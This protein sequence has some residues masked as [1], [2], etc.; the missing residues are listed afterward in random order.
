MK[1]AAS[2]SASTAGGSRYGCGPLNHSLKQEG[3]N[4]KAPVPAARGL[5]KRPSGTRPGAPRGTAQVIAQVIA[6]AF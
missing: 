6:P 4:L 3:F 5:H 1:E 2:P